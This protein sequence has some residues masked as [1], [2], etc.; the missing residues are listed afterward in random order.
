MHKTVDFQNGRLVYEGSRLQL[1]LVPVPVE[2]GAIQKEVVVHPGAVVVLPFVSDTEIVFIR[3]TRAAIGRQLLE[4]PAGTLEKDEDPALCAQRELQEETGFAAAH[5][6]PLG[7][8]FNAPGWSTYRLFAFVARGLTAGPQ[9]LDQ[10]ERI[11]IEIVPT[12]DICSMIAD[13]RIV[14]GKSLSS[15]AIYAARY[16]RGSLASL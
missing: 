10:G 13:G 3:N 9:Q 6:E 1:R 12:A 7:S 5:I 14:D 15:L 4:L 8:F 11:D 2:G 16:R